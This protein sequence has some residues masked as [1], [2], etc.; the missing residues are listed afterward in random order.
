MLLAVVEHHGLSFED[1]G[2]DIRRGTGRNTGG[3][4]RLFANKRVVVTGRW[5]LFSQTKINFPLTAPR[6]DAPQRVGLV[7]LDD[8]I[9]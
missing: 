2:V 9:Q 3:L 4:R 8:L 1:P 5:L 6:L 7:Q